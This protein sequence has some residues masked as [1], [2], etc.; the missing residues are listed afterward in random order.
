MKDEE[1]LRLTKKMRLESYKCTNHHEMTLCLILK[2]TGGAILMFSYVMFFIVMTSSTCL[3]SRTHGPQ[4]GLQLVCIFVCRSQ[5]TL[6]PSADS[7]THGSD[8]HQ[9]MSCHAKWSNMPQL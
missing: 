1:Q 7:I 2:T 5:K 4:Q 8:V 9:V 3:V 6:Y